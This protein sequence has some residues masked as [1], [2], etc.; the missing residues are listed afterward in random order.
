MLERVRTDA[1][2]FKTRS[3]IVNV[4]TPRFPEGEVRLKEFSDSYPSVCSIAI[5]KAGNIPTIYIAG[6][7][8]STDQPVELYNSWGQIA[9]GIEHG[10]SGWVSRG[11]PRG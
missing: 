5:E 10:G 4:R 9:D 2:H 1:G 6:E 11:D 7:S 8:T 3:F